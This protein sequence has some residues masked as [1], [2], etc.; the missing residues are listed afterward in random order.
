MAPMTV[1]VF[2]ATN[3]RRY[4]FGGEGL[5]GITALRIEICTTP[6]SASV[7]CR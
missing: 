2:L 6:G 1:E 3:W 5:C 7:A 4:I